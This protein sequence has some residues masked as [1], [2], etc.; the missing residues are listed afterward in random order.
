MG[1]EAGI[2]PRASPWGRLGT[3]GHPNPQ[4]R[5]PGTE[6]PGRSEAGRPPG[7]GPALALADASPSSLHVLP[8]P[9]S[10]PWTARGSPGCGL[11]PAPTP[12]GWQAPRTCQLPVLPADPTVMRRPQNLCLGRSRVEPP[13][14]RPRPVAPREKG[15]SL[16][17]PKDPEQQMGQEDR[18]QNGPPPLSASPPFPQPRARSLR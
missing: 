11:T 3:P 10:P 5:A 6:H 16:S 1:L 15:W 12:S 14:D 13:P 2:S 18:G 17:P 4:E 9:R 8:R 7:V